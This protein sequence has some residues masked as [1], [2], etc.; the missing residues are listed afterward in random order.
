MGRGCGLRGVPRDRQNGG[1]STGYVHACY[2]KWVGL[3]G[4]CDLMYISEWALHGLLYKVGGAPWVID[5]YK[6]GG[7]PWVIDLYMKVG[8]APWVIDLYMKVG[9]APW[10]CT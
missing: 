3:H 10:G 7:A 5:L 2:G 8:G 1:G 4:S 9:G 6:V